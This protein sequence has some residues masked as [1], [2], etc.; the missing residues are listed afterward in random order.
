MGKTFAPSQKKDAPCVGLSQTL[1]PD[2][3]PTLIIYFWS[4]LKL[5]TTP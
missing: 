1:A 3:K 4:Q 5:K 2:K